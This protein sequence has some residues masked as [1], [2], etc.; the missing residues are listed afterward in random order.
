MDK[1]IPRAEHKS[2]NN[3]TTVNPN[4][5][6][7]SSTAVNPN[8][9]RG[10]SASSE[11]N[12]RNTTPNP[13]ANR[14]RMP[15]RTS[16]YDM[17]PIGTAID[18][19]Y[20]VKSLMPSSGA[21]AVLYVGTSTDTGE[22][23]CIKLYKDSGHVRTD[24]R[25][26]LLGIHHKN[27]AKLHSWG[28]WNGL[29]YEVWELYQGQT[30]QHIIEK[31]VLTR[32]LTKKYLRHMNKALHTIHKAGI[33]HQDIKPA[34]F[35][36][37][38][39]GT[40]V[41]IDFGVSGFIDDKDR[42]HITKIGHTTEYSAPEVL[43]GEFC[44]MK[45]DYYSLG[46]TVY[47]MLIG[48]TPYANFD[49]AMAKRKLDHIRNTDIP[50]IE[51]LH[52]TL[53]HLIKGLL[54]YDS[55]M[56]WGF[57]AVRAWLADD[58]AQYIIYRNNNNHDHNCLPPTFK[59][60]GNNFLIPSQIPQLIY[61]MAEKWGQG[62]KLMDEEGR[63]VLLRN[64]VERIDGAGELWQI[65]NDTLKTGT[66][67][68]HYFNQLYRLC[69]QMKFFAWRGHIYENAQKLGT[70]ILSAM[71]NENIDK[72][73]RHVKSSTELFNNSVSQKI[74]TL[75]YDELKDMF[76]WHVVSLYLG[77]IGEKSLESSVYAIENQLANITNNNKS[78]NK[79]TTKNAIDRLY[80]KIGYILSKSTKLVLAGTHYS[81]KDAFVR[82]VNKII[83]DCNND[84]NN[85]K[86]IS[87][88]KLIYNDDILDAAVDPGFFSW[89]EAV[90]F[91]KEIS[92]FERSLKE[93]RH[94]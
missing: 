86:F 21:E 7:R 37:L 57:D 25:D 87:F 71:W 44:S 53:N 33:V 8:A 12:T 85:D 19:K 81:T 4:A 55:D 13:N 89:A 66:K 42:T 60:A 93:M 69:P 22:E 38:E 5:Q 16:S 90:G 23:F 78:A 74:G 2:N 3:S 72:N 40:V 76:N 17:V 48:R 62:I 50:N 49:H 35:M 32:T 92:K 28:Y 75:G 79:E 36:V 34:N 41:L 80:F 24:V 91:A 70:A 77:Y 31:K 30:L 1:N 29:L 51:S 20:Q 73:I 61:H 43:I 10:S 54:C 64:A 47:E 58:Y 27:V 6:R 82:E 59:F 88:C 9:Q 18:G 63:L 39:D 83:Q 52:Y 46:V 67:D 26:V 56:R 11:A 65:C 68:L 94:Q 14:G 45:S 84:G 15:H